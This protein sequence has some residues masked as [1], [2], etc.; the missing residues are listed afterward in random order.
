MRMPFEE[1]FCPLCGQAAV[2]VFTHDDAYRVDC[3]CCGTFSIT[4]TLWSSLDVSRISDD[5]IRLYNY[6]PSYTRQASEN[7][8]TAVLATNNWRECAQRHMSTPIAQ[9][10]RKCVELIAKRAGSYGNS[11]DITPNLDYPLVDVSSAAAIASLLNDLQ[12]RGLLI[13]KASSGRL[14]CT[15]TIAGWEY[16]DQ[17]NTTANRKESQGAHIHISGGTIQGNIVGNISGDNAGVTYTSH[18]VTAR[19]APVATPTPPLSA[20]SAGMPRIFLCHANEDKPQIRDVYHRLKA[21]GF[22]P[23]LDEE[24]LLPGQLWNQEIRRALRASDFILIFFS[25]NS[26]L[27]R[28]YVQREM[29]LALDTWEEVPEGQIHTIPIRLDVCQIPERFKPFQWVDLFVTGGLERLIRAIRAGV[30]QRQP[31]STSP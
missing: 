12:M 26:V 6:L 9:K 24:D 23:W 19:Q 2:V 21:E 5:D 11:A 10:I 27:K 28:G 16:L 30:T 7:G 29:K 4:R 15:L 1:K 3:Q 25:Q 20:E 13:Y 18:A 31:P 17:L 22:Q 8:T 14:T